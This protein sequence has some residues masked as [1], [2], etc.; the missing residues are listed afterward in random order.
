[1]SDKTYPIDVIK[2]KRTLDSDTG[3]E[4]KQFLQI[5]A[6]ELNSL[7]EVKDINDPVA[8]AVEVKACKKA[9]EKIKDIL[10]YLLTWENANNKGRDKKDKLVDEDL[11]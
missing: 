1:M 6:E 4:M 5:K 7:E 11:T 10:S 9:Y 8:Y 3:Q 2:L